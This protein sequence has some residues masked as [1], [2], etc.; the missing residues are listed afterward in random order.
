MLIAGSG[1]PAGEVVFLLDVDNTLLDDD[2]F[3]ADVEA[4]IERALGRDACLRYRAACRASREAHGHVDYLGALQVLL[5]DAPAADPALLALPDFLLDYPFATCV[6]PG[7]AA[8][9]AHLATL[10]LPVLLS[11]GDLVLQPRRI[12]RAG[13]WGAVQGRV[14]LGLHREDMLDAVEQAYPARHYVVVDD[15]PA[16]LQ[17]ARRKLGGRVTTVF[18]HQGRHAGEADLEHLQPPDLSLARVGELVGLDTS[19]D[20]L[21]QRDFAPMPGPRE[22]APSHAFGRTP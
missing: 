13:L 21:L 10:G 15:E 2:R 6:Y 18:V 7:S 4:E 11:A 17:A 9:L 20:L 5:G 19:R 8:A 3:A 16:Q 14:L 22:A 1:A 12:R